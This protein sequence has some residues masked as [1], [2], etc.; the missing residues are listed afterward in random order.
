MDVISLDEGHDFE[1]LSYVWGKSLSIHRIFFG[2]ESLPI[3][4]NLEA[5]LLKL[6]FP[7][8]QRT[9][10]ID[11]LCI[12]QED[13]AERGQ[14]VGLMGEI[15]SKATDVVVWLGESDKETALVWQ[16]F[17]DLRGLEDFKSPQ[18]YHLAL[19]MPAE[20]FTEVPEGQKRLPEL[21]E[22]FER[23][24]SRPA[25]QWFAM[26]NFLSRP[27]FSR[28]WC[29]QEVVLGTKCVVLCGDYHMPWD[30]LLNGARAIG[31]GRF[32]ILI[33]KSCFPITTAGDIR[34]ERRVGVYASLRLLIYSLRTKGATEPRDKIFAIRSLIDAKASQSLEVD[35]TK[36]LARVYGDAVRACI[37][38][39]ENLSIL[40]DVE[41]RRT[42]ET[43]MPS[44]VPDWRFGHSTNVS[45][46]FRKS[47]GW[48][49][50]RAAGDSKP[51]IRP[52]DN[53][54]KLVL[55]G[56]LLAPIRRFL[57]VAGALELE[58]PC[59][60]KRDL[61]ADR[62][63]PKAW[64]KRYREAVER[65]DIPLSCVRKPE[66]FDHFIAF[67]WKSHI[68]DPPTQKDMLE[69]AFRRTLCADL[70]PQVNM[71]LQDP[72]DTGHW[73]AYE[74]WQYHYFK[75]DVPPQVLLE[76][77]ECVISTMINR[78]FFVA[79]DEDD[80]YMGIALKTVKVGDWVCILHGGDT[81]FVLRP[82]PSS[83]ANIQDIQD[84]EF[85]TDCYV[86]GIMD[87]EAL[88]G[89]NQERFTD[90]DFVLEQYY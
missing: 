12:D 17:E 63:K 18:M 73:P 20:H 77:D 42:V 14:Q 16:L 47:N 8:K 62:W 41:V 40:S 65:L 36:S 35:Y 78:K 48:Q 26:G 55:K 45:L 28:I 23:L 61:A 32:D 87:G 39:D 88:A 1:A 75:R 25:S 56:F 10:W 22:N 79:G 57:D 67:L 84:W 15:Y 33:G 19:G 13:M 58:D 2:K 82:A 5:A 76:H 71:R 53:P 43:S 30:A 86:H 50:Y 83:S 60:A 52:T 49:Y 68:R 89:R 51:Y 64:S 81:P 21:S 7:D 6:R 54:M 59:I 3:T 90:K 9:L 69:T 27:W 29:F 80:A 37:L 38:H 4:E 85:L 44:W 66:K 74:A 72:E 70:L 31:R 46:G 11:Q 34:E 24:R